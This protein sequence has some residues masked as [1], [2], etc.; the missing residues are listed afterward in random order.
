MGSMRPR[1]AIL[2]ARVGAFAFLAIALLVTACASTA[3]SPLA[4]EW[5]DLGNAWLDKGDWKKAG[6]AYS[7]ALAL[8]PSL[9][10][11]SF[12]MARA[13]A[14]AG[15]YKGS[16][17]ILDA[18]AKRDPGNVRVISAR[19]Y[20]LYR[21]GDAAAA[22]IAYREALALDPYAPDA[23]YNV[24]LLEFTAGDA[25]TAAN[26]LDRLTSAKPDDGQA[27]LLLGRAR[28]KTGEADAALAAYEKA[29]ALGKAD[30]EAL[31]RM[32]A[33]YES[34]RRYSEAM[35]AL[36]AAVKDDP[37]RAAAWFG[38]ARLRLVVA[39]DSEKGLEAHKGALAAGFS[40]KD[41][42]SALLAEPDLPEREKVFELLKSKSLAE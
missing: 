29:K 25:A 20:T 1:G 42:A 38:L 37:K 28:D 13:L 4:Q 16:M 40:D 32:G 3:P 31:V 35:D 30:A 2:A 8:Q 5:Y 34:S 9:V 22:L 11:A 15:D 14:E 27:L 33:L 41:A 19:A 17:G 39:E 7:R 23:V 21:K 10:G 18:I 26:D 36:D 12:N 6:Q 24:A